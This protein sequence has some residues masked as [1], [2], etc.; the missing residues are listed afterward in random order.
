[1]QLVSVQS[2]DGRARADHH[3]SFRASTADSKHTFR[4]PGLPQHILS[5][6]GAMFPDAAS[7][8]LNSPGAV[9]MFVATGIPH[10]SALQL[11]YQNVTAATTRNV[12]KTA[13]RQEQL[14]RLEAGTQGGAGSTA[15]ASAAA[16]AASNSE[17]GQAAPA[18]S[19]VVAPAASSA[20]ATASAGGAPAT[21]QLPDPVA[22]RRLLQDGNYTYHERWTKDKWEKEKFHNGGPHG[23]YTNCT[24]GVRAARLR[25]W[26]ACLLWPCAEGMR[27]AIKGDALRPVRPTAARGPELAA[28]S[29]HPLHRGCGGDAA[30]HDQGGFPYRGAA[31]RLAALS[32]LV[33]PAVDSAAAPLCVTFAERELRAVES[34]DAP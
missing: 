29:R 20:N 27:T 11:T 32:P 13:E 14:A 15:R 28:G 33:R 10:P 1:M 16:P 5:Y 21:L 18:E 2:V 17:E 26:P 12:N 23:S 3:N 30:H 19:A 6:C 4:S 22:S 31:G 8:T 25:C 7:Q 34:R 9:V 24:R